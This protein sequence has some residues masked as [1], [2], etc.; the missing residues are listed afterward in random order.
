[1]KSIVISTHAFEARGIEI[2]ERKGLGH[3]NSI[4]DALAENLSRA[5]C[6]EYRRRFGFILHHNVDK[7][8]LSGGRASPA[9]G[10]GT[11]LAPINALASDLIKFG[12]CVEYV[13]PILDVGN[14]QCRRLRGRAETMDRRTHAR[15]DQP[16]SSAGARFR[17]LR[18]NRRSLHPPRHD[19]H[20]AP[21]LDRSNSCN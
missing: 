8:L 18:Q 13:F 19:P 14:G 1:M 16:L 20:H 9:F 21:P 3:P 6:R 11:I 10:G 5:L 4:C 12:N 7:V 2:V 17:T 15:L